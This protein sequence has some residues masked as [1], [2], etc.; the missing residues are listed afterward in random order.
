MNQKNPEHGSKTE[1][2]RGRKNVGS[3]DTDDMQP[4]CKRRK[5]DVGALSCHNSLIFMSTHKAMAT[6]YLSYHQATSGQPAIWALPWS[7]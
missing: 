2:G 1:D 5:S 6:R 3:E 4:K 7:S